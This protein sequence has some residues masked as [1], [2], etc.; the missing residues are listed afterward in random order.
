MYANQVQ[1]DRVMWHMATKQNIPA[2]K[3]TSCFDLGIVTLGI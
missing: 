3:L 1:E 2:N